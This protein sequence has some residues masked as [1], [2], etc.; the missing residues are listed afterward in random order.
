MP[1]LTVRDTVRRRDWV[2]RGNEPRG[3][4]RDQG[5]VQELVRTWRLFGVPV[6]RRVV[7]REHVPVHAVIEAGCFGATSWR[8]KFAD[9]IA[10][11]QARKAA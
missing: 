3:Y 4:C 1:L 6:F 10:A 7:D 2:V 9:A 5:T 11:Q 8:S